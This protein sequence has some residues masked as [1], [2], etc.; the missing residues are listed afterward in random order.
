MTRPPVITFANQKGGVGKTT[1][2]VSVTAELSRRGLR[3][4]VIDLDP[5]ANATAW[6]VPEIA[7][8]TPAA[9]TSSDVL[10][11]ATEPGALASA[12][13]ATSWPGV[14][15]VPAELE[16]AGREADRVASPDLR[17]RKVLRGADLSVY[18]LVVIDTNPSLGP[19]LMNA[20]NASDFAVVVT[21]AERFGV[22]GVAQVM[23]TLD[24]VMEDS[25]R[26]LQLAGI[27]VNKF[28]SR[29]AEHVGRWNELVEAYGG[30]VWARIPHRAAA[31][32]A[33]SA[34]VP[35]HRMRSGDTLLVDAVTEL[36][37]SLLELKAGAW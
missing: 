4:L 19:L 37:G 13:I 25:N 18:D 2:T 1:L 24:V 35:I 9:R 8:P 6:L 26:G 11:S 31:A 12:I 10:Y 28:D 16:L 17:L 29:T 30:S 36:T 20:L 27:V 22:N 32:S 33:A 15:L 14:D 7:E 5:Q 21:D 34:S 23:R 3:A